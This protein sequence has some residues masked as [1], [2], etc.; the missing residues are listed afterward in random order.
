MSNRTKQAVQELQNSDLLPFPQHPDALRKYEQA[1]SVERD[2][3]I[4]TEQ[5]LH[6]KTAENFRK[7]VQS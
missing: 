4:Y 6:D 3:K 2:M 7:S 1:T 5:L